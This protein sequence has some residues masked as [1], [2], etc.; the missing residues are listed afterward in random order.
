MS[1]KVI[2]VQQASEDLVGTKPVTYTTK[3][4]GSKEKWVFGTI[5]G[6][7]SLAN[8]DGATYR[9]RTDSNFVRV[10]ALFFN[11]G[12]EWDVFNGY[13][14]EDTSEPILPAVTEVVDTTPLF[15]LGEIVY[16]GISQ[17]KHVIRE[18]NY[19]R[20]HYWVTPLE[21]ENK[22]GSYYTAN[23]LIRT[24]IPL[25]II[26]IH[27]RKRDMFL[28]KKIDNTLVTV[29]ADN[30]SSLKLDPTIFEIVGKVIPHE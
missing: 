12:L 17:L 13:R 29:L 28:V 22:A 14:R 30:A 4:F 23:D 21:G 18:V 10:H 3:E 9:V 1:I 8:N 6:V 2:T 27:Q 24:P 15:E 25:E 19:D 7:D 5:E 11:N 20:Q 26:A 16:V